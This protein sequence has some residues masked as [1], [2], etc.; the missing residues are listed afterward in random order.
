MIYQTERQLKEFEAKLPSD[1]KVGCR[2]GETSG[3]TGAW[4][5]GVPM[6]VLGS[7]RGA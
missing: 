5:S 3:G 1:I 2:G 4:S 7:I 6:W